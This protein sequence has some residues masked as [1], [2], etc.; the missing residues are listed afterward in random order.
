M[1]LGVAL[2][3]GVLGGHGRLQGTNRAL[4]PLQNLIKKHADFKGVPRV[5][6]LQSDKAA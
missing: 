1:L 6:G 4:A 5:F 3:S 2:H